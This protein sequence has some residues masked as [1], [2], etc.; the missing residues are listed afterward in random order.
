GA[1]LLCAGGVFT[2]YQT[3]ALTP[4]QVNALSPYEQPSFDRPAIH[5]WDPKVA[6]AS[7]V[8]MYATF[9][10]PAIMMINREARKDFLIVGFMYAEVAMLTVGITELTKG[11]VHRPRPYVYNSSVDMHTRTSRDGRH[12][13]FS[14]HTS[15]TAALCFTTAK[16]FS[17]YSDNP[18]HEA[19][20]WT[21]AAL[22][23]ALTGY[24]R[25]EAG[26]HFPSDVIAGYLLGGTIGYLIPWLHRKKPIVKGL[27]ISPFSTGD[28]AGLYLSYRFSD[29][30]R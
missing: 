17:D 13:F 6:I 3:R 14:G 10:L 5:N 20:V 22:I 9:A 11:L 7:D 2:H 1:G 28:G 18:T 27:S 16:I 24:L 12:S 30:Q 15:T 26:K 23:P 29:A 21:G 8:L 19:L 25:Y 4:A